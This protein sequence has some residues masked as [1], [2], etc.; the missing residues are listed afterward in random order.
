MKNELKIFTKLSITMFGIFFT[1]G[2]WYATIGFFMLEK[3]MGE[4]IGWAYSSTPLAAI[5]TPCFM[6][7]FAD[8]FMNAEK[9]QAL[10]LVVGG[11]FMAIVPQFASVDSATLFLTFI[12][13]HA[14]CFMPTLGLSNTICLTHLNDP[15]KSYPRVRVFAT[16]GWI[17]AGLFMSAFLMADTSV[18]Q[19][20]IAA[21]SSILTGIFSFLLPHT[22]P[23][24]ENKKVAIGDL[25]GIK[26][27]PYFKNFKFTIFMLA[28]FLVCIGMMPYWAN[29]ATF[30]GHAGIDHPGAFLTL[31]QITELFV[32]SL[33]LPFFIKKFG[34]KWTMIIGISSWILRYLVFSGAAGILSESSQFSLQIGAMLTV[35]VV[36][37]GFAYDFVFISGYLYIDKIV[38]SEV[39][40]QAQALLTVFTQGIGF[41]LSA[42][43]FS[44]IIYNQ[45]VGS[46]PTHQNFQTFWLLPV[47][48]L[49]IVL[50]LFVF[51][52]KDKT[53]R[54]E[55]DKLL[56][57]V[58]G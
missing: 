29:G 42:Q 19:F 12:F 33:I 28:S 30:L 50:F 57:E 4:Y 52:F 44:G 2:S 23:T 21:V 56:S 46:S 8:R 51:L 35:G 54:S 3:G 15:E 49:T 22:I 25:L 9:L 31:G 58:S 34:I 7:A 43:I 36:L 32:L 18:I 45:V 40:A 1:W 10:L 13:L 41:L 26:V 11:V 38:K 20:Y 6:G 24:S 14:L 55:D 5:V 39:R 17:L 16:L 48:L 27:F 53:I 47:I 37:H